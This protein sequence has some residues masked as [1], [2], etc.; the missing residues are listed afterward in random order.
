M[1]YT[2]WIGG[3]HSSDEAAKAAY[4]EI[5]RLRSS[6]VQVTECLSDIVDG[7]SGWAVEEVIRDARFTLEEI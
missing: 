2:T 7:R 3:F 5:Q 1:S 6:L 4:K